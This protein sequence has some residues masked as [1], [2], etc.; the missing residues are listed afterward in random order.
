MQGFSMHCSGLASQLLDLKYKRSHDEKIAGEQ[1]PQM[2]LFHITN[3]E[4]EGFAK[5]AK[6]LRWFLDETQQA[7]MKNGHDSGYWA[8]YHEHEYVDYEFF[9]FFEGYTDAEIK[10]TILLLERV[11]NGE[12]LSEDDTKTAMDFL[13]DLS[14]RA[15]ARTN[16]GGCF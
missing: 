11:G 4:R 5:F 7:H 15:Y 6:N 12:E 13:H 8:E 10:P 3:E 16:R 2:R 14:G 1:E 9:K